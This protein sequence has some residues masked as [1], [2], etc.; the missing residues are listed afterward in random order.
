MVHMMIKKKLKAKK[1]MVPKK[2]PKVMSPPKAFKCPNAGCTKSFSYQG[3]LDNH[4]E[5]SC[6]RDASKNVKKGFKCPNE[7]CD[8]SFQSQVNLTRHMNYMCIR[9]HEIFKCQNEGC[10]AIF[11][12]KNLLEAHLKECKKK[13]THFKCGYCDYVKKFPGY[14]I[15]HC[16]E[17]HP[18][19][20]VKYSTLELDISLD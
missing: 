12:M 16:K 14:V 1:M 13:E 17:T 9:E 15:N 20:E 5:Y 8:R 10:N 3:N 18:D 19:L 6:K 11:L 7:G 2:E 4:M